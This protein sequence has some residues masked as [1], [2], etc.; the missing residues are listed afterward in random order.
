MTIHCGSLKYS[1]MVYYANTQFAVSLT[2]TSCVLQLLEPPSDVFGRG[3]VLHIV[4][5]STESTLHC[6]HR[7]GPRE[8]KD[9]EHFLLRCCH[10][11]THAANAVSGRSDWVRWRGGG[12]TE[13]YPGNYLFKTLNHALCNGMRLFPLHCLRAAK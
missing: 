7:I 11:D 12:T 2:Q 8:L 10:S 6:D 13:H 4:K 5:S 9:T 1:E 3:P